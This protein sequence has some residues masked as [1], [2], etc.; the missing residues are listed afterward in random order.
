MIMYGLFHPP[1]CKHDDDDDDD[2]DDKVNGDVVNDD[3][4]KGARS[5][6]PET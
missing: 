6:R 2:D 1:G 5:L 3:G 4:K